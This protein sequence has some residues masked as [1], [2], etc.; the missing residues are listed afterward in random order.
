M[1][2]TVPRTISNAYTVAVWG[3]TKDVA[4][5]REQTEN[6]RRQSPGIDAGQALVRSRIRKKLTNTL[7]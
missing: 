6:A 7:F 5:Q 1:C 2:F 4:D 3:T